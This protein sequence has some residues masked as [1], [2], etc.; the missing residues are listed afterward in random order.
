MAECTPVMRNSMPLSPSS[1]PPPSPPPPQP[2]TSEAAQ[3]VTQGNIYGTCVLLHVQYINYYNDL[4]WAFPSKITKR[5]L[6]HLLQKTKCHCWCH[7]WSTAIIS[8]GK[9]KICLPKLVQTCSYISIYP[10]IFC[11]LWENVLYSRW[12]NFQKKKLSEP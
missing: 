12:N 4:H 1:L 7:S 6:L 9:T 11:A 3:P 10:S 8:G 5:H 2:S